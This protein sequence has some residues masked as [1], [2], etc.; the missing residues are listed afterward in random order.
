MSSGKRDFSEYLAEFFG[1][2]LLIVF[3]LGVVAV[4]FLT[5]RSVSQWEISI[6]WGLA[7]A[8]A[9]Y[10][11][12]GVSGAHI[13]PSVTV[14]LAVFGKF[15]WRKVLPFIIAQTLGAFVAAA[16]VWF[17]YQNLFEIALGNVAG[18]PVATLNMARIFCTFPDPN[19]TMTQAF[20]TEVFITAMLMALI[21]ALVDDGN[22]LPRGP[23]AP[24]LIGLVIA[25]IGIT[26]GPLTGF[27]MNA[28]RD[29]GPRLFALLAGWGPDV[30]TGY[31]LSEN[32]TIPYFLVPL[33]APIVG[34]CVG[35]GL[36]RVFVTRAL[37]MKASG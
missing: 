20:M 37:G 24:L 26:F 15:P 2:F 12:A 10:L 7:V 35:A 11:C 4:V 19:I 29:M 28:A 18:D 32:I 25:L 27:A 36:Y 33:I 16:V 22:G 23:L 21:L 34:A 3:G 6:A 17:L 30:M 9:V 5:G 31:P 8:M 1:T 14:A 13:N